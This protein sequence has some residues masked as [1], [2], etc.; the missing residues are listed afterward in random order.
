MRR[1]ALVVA[2]WLGMTASIGNAA[3]PEPGQR[4]EKLDTN[5]DGRLSRQ[6]AA[7]YPE[8]AQRF[9]QMDANKDGFLSRDELASK[10]R[11]ICG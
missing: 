4:F 5:A 6:E 9:G 11:G 3:S 7:A 2:V 1:L 10:H 8:I